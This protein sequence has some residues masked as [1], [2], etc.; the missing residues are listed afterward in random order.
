VAALRE[1]GVPVLVDAAHGPGMLDVDVERLGADYWTGNLHKWVCAP[2]GAA[3]L[4]TELGRRED[5]RPLVTSHGAGGGLFEEFHWPGT[6]DPTAWLAAP[7]ALDVLDGLGWERLRTHNHALVIQG[8]DTLA[9]A[10]GT[11]PPV[12]EEA[13]G[14]MTIVPLPNG[15]VA[16]QEEGWA[17]GWRLFDEHRIEVPVT[18]WSGR[19]F[20]RISAHAY[21]HP[22]EYER[23]A[24]VLPAML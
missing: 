13:T 9:H 4:V 19:A 1:R 22:A 18:W 23:L 16:S 10:L 6:D 2:K 14:W 12:P 3:V 17:L 15:A 11:I 24:R 8:R 21:N 20:V 7:T 5:L